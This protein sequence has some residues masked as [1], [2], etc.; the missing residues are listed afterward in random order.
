MR[1][2]V[3]RFS[4]SNSG[5]CEECNE[6]RVVSSSNNEKISQELL[7]AEEEPE[8]MEKEEQKCGIYLR[9]IWGMH[10]INS[11]TTQFFWGKKSIYVF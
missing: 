10:C 3:S 5:M 4:K 7:N 2:E 9:A 6:K 8:R 11:S 1:R